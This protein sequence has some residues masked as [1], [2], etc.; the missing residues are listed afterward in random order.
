MEIDGGDDNEMQK[1]H[2][3][4]NFLNFLFNIFFQTASYWIRGRGSL[5]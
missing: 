5:G 2:Q 4:Y 1:I 3:I